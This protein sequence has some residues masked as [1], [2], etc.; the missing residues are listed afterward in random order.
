MGGLPSLPSSCISSLPSLHLGE[1]VLEILH[2]EL[3]DLYQVE[4]TCKT[5]KL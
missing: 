2:Y 3:Y 1:D 5:K 4:F